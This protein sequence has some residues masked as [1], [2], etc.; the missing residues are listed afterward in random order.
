M[1]AATITFSKS[2]YAMA[3]RRRELCIRWFCRARQEGM[4]LAHVITIL[5]SGRNSDYATTRRILPSM[6]KEKAWQTCVQFIPTTSKDIRWI[7]R[8]QLPEHC[9]LK[10]EEVA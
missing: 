8:L 6:E 7:D 1:K 9:E 3:M 4:N 5:F 10:W 2:D